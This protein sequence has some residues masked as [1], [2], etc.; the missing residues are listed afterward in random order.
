MI[1]ER[2]NIITSSARPPERNVLII[3]TGG[4]LGMIHGE[5]GVLVPFDF[6]SILQHVPS[7]RQLGLNLTVVSFDPPIDSSN[8][9][10]EYWS[11]IARIIV[12]DYDKFDGFV[13]LHGTDTMAYTASA[14]SFM[15]ENLGKPV[16]FTG[17]QLPITAFRSDA[18]ENLITSLEIAS[19]QENGKPLVPEVAIYFNNVLLRA[20]RSKKVESIHFDAFESE[21]YPML[22]ESGVVLDYHRRMILPLPEGPLRLH[23]KWDD[24]VVILKLFP[25]MPRQVVEA[26]TAMTELRGI[27]LETFGA[28]NAI[29]ESWFIDSLRVSIERGVVIINVSQCNGGR[30]M[31]GRYETSRQLEAIGVVGGEDITT[32]AAVTKLMILLGEEHDTARVKKRFKRPL[33]GEMTPLKAILN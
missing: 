15:L 20:N 23:E 16:I 21:N 11:V 12:Q 8:M 22:A 2:I 26:V 30:V 33:C 28:G 17:A 6:A 31:Q 25:G 18:R 14:V 32:E 10:P 27:V 7:L 4:T 5:D 13:V 24:R 1:T 29:S 9:K 3:Y 19:G